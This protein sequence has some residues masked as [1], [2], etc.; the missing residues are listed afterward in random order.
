MLAGLAACTLLAALAGPH[1]VGQ[2]A[3]RLAAV[4]AGAHALDPATALRESLLAGAVLVLPFVLAGLLASVLA[5]LL[6]TGFLVSAHPLMPDL[7]RLSP[8]RGF[9]RLFGRQGVV[10]AGLA[11]LKLG[12]A[13][14]A[15]WRVL[16]ALWPTLPPTLLW[17]TDALLR[18]TS[19][20]LL[21][22]VLSV[23]A[24]Q[25][26]LVLLDLLRVR[27]RHTATLRMSRH[28][29]RE[30]HKETEGD[31]H[32]KA[33]IRRIRMQRARRR[34]LQSVPKAAAVVTNPT[35]YA[36]ALAYDRGFG[37]GAPRVVAKG[38][39]ELATRI[40][41]VAAEHGVPLVANPPLA[42]SLFRVE[43]DAEIPPE[44]FHAVAEVIAY[45]WRLRNERRAAL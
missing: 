10:Q 16:G 18:G 14:G 37:A 19:G 30:E 32:I 2:L 1:L 29:L 21:R 20:Q 35:H 17:D 38:V 26:L 6:Q 22:L 11:L 27:L 44:L 34:M 41:A 13:V 40:R 9:G 33:R 7:G 3:G 39:D 42:R 28:E 43:L 45:V 25:T 15:A 4:L 8:A 23:L 24:A 36:V 31:P 12:V 5:V